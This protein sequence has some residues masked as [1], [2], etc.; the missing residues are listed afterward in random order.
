MIEEHPKVSV[1]VPMTRPELGTQALAS[2][3][4]QC[5]RGEIETIVVE[6]CDNSLAQH[7]SITPVNRGPVPYPGKARN[8]GVSHATGDVLLF[9][10]DDCTVEEDWVARNVQALKQPAVGVVGARIRGKSGTFFARCTDFANF[11]DYQHGR[12]MDIPVAAASL[13]MPRKLFHA[14]S[15]FNETK[16]SSEDMDLCYRVQQLGY[17]TV[18]RP[19]IVVT[20]N[21]RRD[22]LGKLLRHN[23]AHGRESGLTTKIPYQSLGLKNRLLASVRFPPL[24]LLLLPLIAIAATARIVIVNVRTNPEVLLYVPVIFL[25]KLVYEFG[26]FRHLLSAA[27]TMKHF[28]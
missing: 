15:G 24:F 18:Y 19:D 7:W 23:Y 8:L 13:A 21:H 3:R 5:Y 28:S 16:R 27:A 2:I 9:L 11:G 10:D 4:Q 6:A 22:T 17:R 20:H 12:S 14:I 26:V 25:A 1:I